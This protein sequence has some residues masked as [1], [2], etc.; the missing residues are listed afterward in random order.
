MS[1]HDSE[2]G[3]DGVPEQNDVT[4]TNEDNFTHQ[5]A[6][7]E[8]S[9][10]VATQTEVGPEDSTKQESDCAQEMRDVVGVSFTSGEEVRMNQAQLRQEDVNSH[11]SET[12]EKLPADAVGNST[13]T[14]KVMLMP[15]GYMMTKAFTIGLTTQDLKSHFAQELRVPSEVLQI[16]FEGESVE[17]N[18]T[19]VDLGVQPHGTV[20]LEMRSSDPEN[21]PI[22]PIKPQQECIMPDVITVR[23]PTGAD[24]FQDVVVEIERATRG[25]AFLGGYRHRI[26]KMEYHHAAV[27]TMPKKRPDRCIEM[28]SR[29]TQTVITK[30][31]AQQCSSNT[32]TQTAGIGCYISNM[33]DKLITPGT[34][35]TAEQHHS[36]R[37]NAVITLQRYVRA[38]QAKRFMAQLKQDKEQHQAWIE[39]EERRKREEKDQQIRDEY[40]RRMNPENK[41]DFALLY[42][43]LEKWRRE[44]VEQ[45]KSSLSGEEQK[46]ALYALLE[47]EA[48]LIASIGRHHNEAG[49][50]NQKKATENLLNKCA[51]PKS[52]RTSNGKTVEMDTQYT[53]RAKELRD[54]Y[55]SINPPYS[56]QEERLDLLLSLKHTVK[57][58]DCTLTREIVELID[59]EADLMRRDVKE[60]NLRGLR[61]RISTLFLQYIKTPIF[62][63]EVSKHL[64]VSQD[65]SQ[66]RQKMYFCRACRKSR[67]STDFAL[68]VNTR[69]VG[70]CRVCTE[71]DNQ[72]R[73]REDFSQYKTILKRLRKTEEQLNPDA[74]IIHLLQEQDLKYLVDLIWEAQSA[75]SAWDDLHDL[76]MV[77]W[78]RFCQWSPWNC[79]L[80]TQDEAA[81]HFK[82]E[83][84]EQAYGLMFVRSIKHKHTLAQRYFSQI[85]AMAQYLHDVD[86]QPAAAHG[87]LLLTKPITELTEQ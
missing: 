31:Q 29:D 52:W 85:P 64:R 20:Q 34:Y 71:T 23:V 45:I 22:R 65:P 12:V 76:V 53:I 13:A 11:G 7:S 41:E 8:P 87:D 84:I 16:S 14:V 75:L 28:F 73:Q 15:E 32:S 37:L 55:T 42:N 47:Q 27:Q 61:E 67:P 51:A 39:S 74:K 69:V 81:L 44:E 50:R 59:R 24:A 77:R 35:I 1:R 79:I 60:R 25:K 56:S 68:N 72:A 63:P 46:K 38:W 86:S 58:H 43:A 49:E 2:N 70:R 26:T 83:N 62:N 4:D 17:D 40:N 78:D 66:L 36:R 57:E 5:N 82:T 54:L 21:H 30:S 9:Q 6:E 18:Q 10:I 19:L 48:R 80:L 33:K 3:N